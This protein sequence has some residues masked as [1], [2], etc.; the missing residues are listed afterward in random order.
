ME[1]RSWHT[2]ASPLPLSY[3]Q[4]EARGFTSLK[5]KSGLDKQIEGV[6]LGARGPPWIPMSSLKD[7]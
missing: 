5:L 6:L 4:L 7:S 1:P 3:T 2:Q